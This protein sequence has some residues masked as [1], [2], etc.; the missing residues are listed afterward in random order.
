VA[1]VTAVRRLRPGR[2]RVDVDG[3]EWRRLPLEVAVRA[4]L[5]PDVELD[6][7]RLRR[8]RRE[9][10]R[11]EALDLACRA[12]RARDLSARRLEQ[13]LEAGGVAPANRLEAMATLTRAGLLDDRRVAEARAEA[14]AARGLGDAAVRFELERQGLAADLIEQAVAGL[15]PEEERAR[16]AAARAGGGAG[17]ARR[18]A[19]KGFSDEAIA[20]AVGVE[21]AE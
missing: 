5:A 4:G 15:A 8:L 16:E 14:L 6:R 13:R 17:A 11:W 9:L 12:L 21:I 3:A 7:P 1:R 20:A 19:R 10:R 18:L 2:V